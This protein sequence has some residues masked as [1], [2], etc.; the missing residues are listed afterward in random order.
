MRKYNFDEIGIN[1][2]GKIKLKD[3]VYITDPC[4]DTNTWCQKYLKGVA[5]GKYICYI[6]VSDENDWGHRVSELH[7]V[8]ES[9]LE[10]F[11]EDLDKLPYNNE[12]LPCVIGVDSGQCGI[13]DAD[14]YEEHQPDNDYHNPNSWYRKVCDLTCNAG[15]IDGLGVAT[16]SGYGDGSYPLFIAKEKDKIVAMK[17]VFIG[18]EENKSTDYC[19]F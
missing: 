9:F 15:I 2:V 3:K 8:K 11:D 16:A 1:Q 14:Y 6:N 19:S 4:Y 17:V 5:P 7:V 13:F 18:F 12:P 10:V